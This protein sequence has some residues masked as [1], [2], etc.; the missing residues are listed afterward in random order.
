MK[1]LKPLLIASV[2]IACSLTYANNND[3]IT[4]YK[5]VVKNGGTNGFNQTK[6]NLDGK[7]LTLTASGSGY[8][9]LSFEC[10]NAEYPKK[11]NELIQTIQQEINSGN[12]KGIIVL[13]GQYKAKWNHKNDFN[14]KVIIKKIK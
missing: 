8:S 7:N 1:I 12:K 4:R 5:R 6:Q 9:K 10:C 2:L 11:M 3:E 14:S 13:K